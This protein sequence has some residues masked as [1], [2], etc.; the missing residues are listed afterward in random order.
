MIIYFHGISK[1][2]QRLRIIAHKL[3]MPT[4]PN[5][6][7]HPDLVLPSQLEPAK[8]VPPRTGQL[9]AVLLRHG[10]E[11]GGQR[12]L[13]V[14]A[15]SQAQPD[16]VLVPARFGLHNLRFFHHSS[17]FFS[18]L[19]HFFLFILL[20]WLEV[21]DH[22]VARVNG[23]LVPHHSHFERTE[24]NMKKKRSAEKQQ[25]KKCVNE[26]QKLKNRFF[27]LCSDWRLSSD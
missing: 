3:L 19:L 21:R 14:F 8:S 11:Q 15:L 17:T 9:K 4:P 22:E 24:S 10:L 6:I 25:R 5:H 2:A 27:S 1:S 26:Q 20:V 16:L 23:G 7:I 18:S 12:N 13:V